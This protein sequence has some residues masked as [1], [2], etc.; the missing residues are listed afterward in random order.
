MCLSVLIIFA[1]E[2]FAQVSV[3]PRVPLAAK[4]TAAPSLRSDSSLV[5]VPASVTDLFNRPVIGLT[6][7]NFRIFDNNVEQ[8]LVSLS[9]EDAPVAIA[10]VFDASGS[11]KRKM[12]KSRMAVAQL[13]A[14][15]NP[16]DEFCLIQFNDSVSLAHS[17]TSDPAEIMG[18]ARR[19]ARERP[20][21]AARRHRSR[22]AGIEEL[23]P[24]AKGA[25]GAVRWRGQPQ[26]SQRG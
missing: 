20:D 16:E 7:S 2:G 15:A 24:A 12:A 4:R 25:R 14:T 9:F 21:R 17:W 5:L 3:Q 18:S 22:A 26:P 19:H 23:Q 11:M 1:G 6:K 8:Q 10:V 13:L